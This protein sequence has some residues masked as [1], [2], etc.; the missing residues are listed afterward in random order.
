[1]RSCLT[2][3]VENGNHL[4]I[5]I[6]P[7]V[8]ARGP[9]MSKITEFDYRVC[10]ACFQY[11]LALPTPDDFNRAVIVEIHMEYTDTA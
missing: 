1:M 3:S 2:Q 7:F 4:K 10:A 5:R 8:T 11:K 9:I 6:S